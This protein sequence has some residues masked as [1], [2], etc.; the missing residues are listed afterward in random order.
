MIIFLH[1]TEN[2]VPIFKYILP[3]IPILIYSQSKMVVI[4][5]LDS[6]NVNSIKDISN[7]MV[8]ILESSDRLGDYFI[9][10]NINTDSTYYYQYIYEDV[11]IDTMVQMGYELSDRVFYQVNKSIMG[12]QPYNE[13]ITQFNR[14]INSNSFISYSSNLYYGLTNNKKIGAIIDLDTNFKNYFSGLVGASNSNDSWDITGQIDLHLENQWRSANIIELHWKRLDEESQLLN[15]YVEEPYPFGLPIGVSI[16]F[17]QDLRDGNFVNNESAVGIIKTVPGVAKF[18]FGGSTKNINSTAKG[19]SLGFTDLANNSIYLTG[20]ID[21][22]NDIWLATSGHYASISVDIGE[23]TVNDSN[24]VS[25]RISSEFGKYFN[26]TERSNL[27]IKVNSHGKWLNKGLIHDGE[28]IRYGGANNL[29]GYAEDVFKSE[30]VIIP[31]IEYSVKFSQNQKFIVFS[32]L[33][34]QD[35]YNQLPLG[36]GFGLTQVT[37]SSI[38]KIDFGI[39]R[40]DKLKNGKVHLQLLTK[41]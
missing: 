34:I 1:L 9:L 8:S 29:R 14:I 37:K 2:C 12:T 23:C 21:R 26:I 33:A 5:D 18:G 27:F 39:G 16:S 38:F 15:I 3:I 19:D 22:R 35:K 36:I 10:D 40:G 11:Y 32:D 13:S 20:E 7:K 31:T 25:A 30:W 28:L 41:L 6:L 4:D 17:H 24:S